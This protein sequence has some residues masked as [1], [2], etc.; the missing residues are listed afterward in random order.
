MGTVV[1]GW[2]KASQLAARGR[3]ARTPGIACA[4]APPPRL[5]L[6]NTRIAWLC[7]ASMQVG[8]YS[9]SEAGRDD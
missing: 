9:A 7:G 2:L 8:Q 5:C 4:F 3:E 6:V 1:E